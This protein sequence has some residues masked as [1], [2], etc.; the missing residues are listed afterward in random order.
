VN[1]LQGTLAF[2]LGQPADIYDAYPDGGI[3]SEYIEMYLTD[4]TADTCSVEL[5][6]PDAGVPATETAIIEL[7]LVNP[8]SALQVGVAYDSLTQSQEL[9]FVEDGGGLPS[10]P[11][12][13]LFF[14]NDSTQALS[15]GG[16]M[17]LSEDS[18]GVWDATFSTTMYDLSVGTTSTLQGNIAPSDACAFEVPVP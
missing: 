12:F 17:T 11:F 8:T 5:G 13:Q 10:T 15:T 2:S 16:T 18:E 9:N 7:Q 1:T 6:Y 14:E 4:D 3:E